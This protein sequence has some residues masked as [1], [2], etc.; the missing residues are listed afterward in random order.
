[1]ATLYMYDD[2][3]VSLIPLDAKIIACYNDG[4]Y[5]NVDA[6]RARFPHAV[7]VTIAVRA[8]DDAEVLDD[9]PGDATDAE[10]YAWLKRQHA[11]GVYCPV[12]YKSAGGVDRLMLTMTANG[13]VHGKDFL[14][15]SAHY[16]N[17]PHICGPDTCKLTKIECDWTQSTDKALG[18]S[19]DESM[20]AAEPSFTAPVT[21]QPAPVYAV[22]TG[23][24]ATPVLVLHIGWQDTG[25]PHYR[26]QVFDAT[27]TCIYSEVVYD[28]HASIPIAKPGTVTW[29]VQ[30]A[31]NSPWTPMHSIT[32]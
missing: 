18:R 2:V 27:G 1:M 13:F 12:I 25:S 15:W 29:H 4:R 32:V 7:I 21:V 30:S 19:L 5:K 16:G 14:I 23:L 3:T 22:P 6:V 26:L 20:L 10:V 8:S 31:G 11:R 28:N 9:E 17:G 24:S